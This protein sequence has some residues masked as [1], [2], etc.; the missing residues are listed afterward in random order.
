MD[1]VD[2]VALVDDDEIFRFLTEKIIKLTHLAKQVKFFCNGEEA[3]NFLKANS[4]KPQLLPDLILLDLNMPV[5]NGWQ[6]IGEFKKIKHR[7]G[8]KIPIFVAS[9]STLRNDIDKIKNISEVSDYI[10][11][12]ITAGKFKE[13]V[14]LLQ[15]NQDKEDCK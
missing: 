13:M 14:T 10:A 8:K 2:T 5:M 7:L 3:I 12:P 9:S 4:D 11:K 15:K 1:P 6:F